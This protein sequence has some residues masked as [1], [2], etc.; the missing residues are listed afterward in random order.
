[1]VTVSCST[2]AGLVNVKMVGKEL[3]AILHGKQ[4]V[5]AVR[6]MMEVNE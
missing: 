2:L 3:A 5:A 6:M 4:N 1:M